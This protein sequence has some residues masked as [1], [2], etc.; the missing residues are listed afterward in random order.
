MERNRRFGV[1]AIVALVVLLLSGCVNVRQ[2]VTVKSD[3]NWDASMSITFP[4]STVDQIGKDQMT[5]SEADFQAQKDEAAKKG[6]K[7]D[8]QV[9]TEDNGDIVWTLTYSGKGLNLLN[10]T[11]FSNTAAFSAGEGGRV[12]FSYDPGDITSLTSMGGSYT[13]VLNA[14]KVYSSNATETKGSTLT[15]KDPTAVMEAEVGVAG[16]GGGGFPTWLIIILVIVG[17][18]LLVVV[19]VVLLYLRGK[20][21]P[22]AAAP[23]APAPV[24]PPSEPP[25]PPQP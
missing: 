24:A 2:E 7:A 12:K 18:L 20:K 16:G 15:W 22:P 19:A 1:L 5:T 25:A 13:F 9:K 17:V 21:T 23:A 8:M 10:T 6:I 11:L 3:E 14:G 4:K